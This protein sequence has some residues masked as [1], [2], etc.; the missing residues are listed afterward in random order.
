MIAPD[1]GGGFGGKL[2]TTPEEW[3]TWCGRPPDRQARA[4]TPRPARSP[5]CRAT[6]AATS[7][8]SSPWPPTKEGSGHRPQGRPARRPRGLRRASSAAACRC[9]ARSCSTRSTSSPPTSSTAPTVLTN[10]TWTDA[11]RGAGR[12]EA[13]YAIERLMDELAA[14]VGMDP[15]ADP[16]D[17]LD[18]A[19]RVPVHHGRRHDLRLRQLRGRHREGQGDVRLRRAAGR[20]AAAPATPATRSSWASASRRSPR[21]AAWRPAGCSAAQ[22]RRRRLGARER[23]GCCRPARSR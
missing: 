12:P 7:G 18:Q 1:V 13:T 6:T 19:R 3:I 8:R 14:E 15:L 21:C 20:A 9:S 16:R 11:Y 2:Q 5:W 4:S 23:C 10:K 17:E 22:L